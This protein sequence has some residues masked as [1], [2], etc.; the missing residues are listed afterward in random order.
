MAVP[1][2]TD[3]QLTEISKILGHTSSGFT[4]RELGELLTSCGFPDPGEITKRDRLFYG[5]SEGQRR[6]R[7]G[8][9]V[10]Q[11]VERAMDPVRYRGQSSLLDER[12]HDLNV[13]LAFA[14]MRIREDGR[15]EP[16]RPA[17]TLS[18]AELRASSLR[19]E[20][21]RRG[22]S[23]DVLAYCRP[24]LL[25]G[26]Y[27]HAAFEAMKSVAQKIRDRTGLILD[28]GALVQEV[29]SIRNGRTPLLAWNPVQSDNDRSEHN[30][31]ALLP[32]SAGSRPKGRLPEYR[33]IRGARDPHHP[34]VRASTPGRSCFHRSHATV[35]PSGRPIVRA[36]SIEGITRRRRPS[37]TPLRS[38]P[39]PRR[40]TRRARGPAGTRLM[41]DPHL[42][43]NPSASPGTA[44][45]RPARLA[46]RSR[47]RT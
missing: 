15:L 24:E 2:F 31:V 34:V 29:F 46:P 20:L 42:R 7:S 9:R 21:M 18:E 23:G 43:T 37:R 45:H 19:A 1:S 10:C 14:G 26:N 6:D 16:V 30:G 8:A 13:V 4:G 40:R 39:W 27:F 12:R 33:R 28:G 38:P 22:I 44:P 32:Q 36:A 25:E 41:L 47:P 5:L 3:N 11:L 35:E 17:A